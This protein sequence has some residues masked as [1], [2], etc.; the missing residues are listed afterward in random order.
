MKPSI[1][2]RLRHKSTSSFD[3]LGARLAAMAAVRAKRRKAFAL[4]LAALACLGGWGAHGASVRAQERA[5][6]SQAQIAIG[7]VQAVLASWT[8]QR[9]YGSLAGRE[10]QASAPW[11]A[12]MA[13][14]VL[15]DASGIAVELAFSS[16]AQ[17]Q[18]LLDAAQAYFE[19]AAVDGTPASKDRPSDACSAM[20]QNALLLTKLDA[21]AARRGAPSSRMVPLQAAPA[22]AEQIAQARPGALSALPP[23]SAASPKPTSRP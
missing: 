4:G 5:G 10:M 15:P 20:G 14:R 6:A 8:P 19:R 1:A 3:A 12:A 7:A 16:Q 22:S 2:A 9:G 21:R 13:A 17:C 23:S 18:G 11:G